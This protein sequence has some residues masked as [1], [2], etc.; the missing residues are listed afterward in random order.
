M[1][2]NKTAVVAVI[3]KNGEILLGKK[4]RDANDPLGG[5]W[6]LPGGY[7]EATE[8][9]E[10]ALKREMREELGIAIMIKDFLASGWREDQHTLVQWYLCT[11]DAS[12]SSLTPGDDVVEAQFIPKNQVSAVCSD[13]ARK[14]W[15]QEFIDYLNT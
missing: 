8:T 7:K 6:H 2:N 1:T 3:E 11:T 4:R 14:N 9:D 10:E 13:R 15:P 12:S 5:D